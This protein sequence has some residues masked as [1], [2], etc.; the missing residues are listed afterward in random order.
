MS[1]LVLVICT[2]SV[3]TSPVNPWAVFDNTSSADVL[4]VRTPLLALAVSKADGSLLNIEGAARTAAA[5]PLL[6][7]TATWVL[8]GPTQHIGNSHG[9]LTFQYAWQQH[10]GVLS[11]EWHPRAG[12]PR[13]PAL[14]M[15]T[16]TVTVS[17]PTA[18]RWFDAALKLDAAPMDSTLYTSVAWPS[19]LV[20]NVT[21]TTGGG[22]FYPQLPG[23]VLAP[24]WFARQRGQGVSIPYPGCGTWCG[25]FADIVHWDYG[26]NNTSVSVAAVSGPDLTVPHYLGF[27]PE[28][29]VGDETGLWRYRHDA[30]VNISAGCNR[31]CTPG[32]KTPCCGVGA[33]GTLL[34][35]IAVG[36]TAAADVELYGVSNGLLPPTPRRLGRAGAPTTGMPP[37]VLV[38]TVGLGP[39]PPLASKVPAALLA[40]LARAPLYKLDAVEAGMNFSAYA[41]DIFPRLPVPGVV[42]FVAFEPVHF[43]R[44][45]PDYLPPNPR[46]GTGCDLRGAFERA[47]AAG[48]LTMPYTNPTWWDPAAP[49]LAG[50]SAHNLTLVDVC[51]LNASGQPI[52]ETYP[53]ATP[54]TGVAVEV[55]HPFVVARWDRL[56]C[57]LSQHAAGCTPAPTPDPSPAPGMACDEAAVVL[58]STLIFEDQVGAR[59]AYADRNAEEAG[60]GALGYQAAMGGHAARYAKLALGTEQGYDKLAR[61]VLGFYGNNIEGVVSPPGWPWHGSAGWRPLPLAPLLFGGSTLYHVHNLAGQAFARSLNNTCY[62]LATGARLSIEVSGIKYWS[63]NEAA[64]YKSVGLFQR[65]VAARWTGFALDN[66][67][68]TPLTRPGGD[69]VAVHTRTVFTN[70]TGPPL[71]PGSST[72]YTVLTN[73]DARAGLPVGPL[74]I[75]DGSGLG[76]GLPPSG[77]MS[78]GNNGD[79]LAG[80]FTTFR[81]RSLPLAPGLPGYHAI[82]EDRRCGWWPVNS[83]APPDAW[84]VCLFHPVGTP[85]DLDV[86]VPPACT[87]GLESAVRSVTVSRA[88]RDRT[89]P[90]SPFTLSR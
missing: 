89:D 34:V 52:Y 5:P 82:I 14:Q 25:T 21:R 76:F 69:T 73:W 65:Y 40:M 77:C 3:G 8:A 49:T 4:F 41:A 60:A 74:T 39:L 44:W 53:D 10:M 12:A 7:G 86:T 72:S 23:L 59:N 42:H 54:A 61:W 15:P 16:V 51:A 35:R 78:Y 79:V 83:S 1:V 81:N 29:P 24:A 58:P 85:A 36:G 11:L 18:A 33:T 13:L 48:H 75:S 87:A 56:M 38:P 55:R 28:A 30:I 45:Y 68:R 43:D 2:W 67:S 71:F 32:A 46:Y 66:Y 22:V 80:W 84:S 37:D 6:V 27:Y 26:A 62:A 90:R 31:T 9:D 19:G 63:T 17:F 20:F 57:Q 47:L 88:C 70:T 50:L 64:W